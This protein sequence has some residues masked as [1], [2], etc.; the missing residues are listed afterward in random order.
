M[1]SSPERD[2]NGSCNNEIII[3]NTDYTA[4]QT[5]D[6]DKAQDLLGSAYSSNN[7]Y[8]ISFC[9]AR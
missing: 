3:D 6:A 2:E 5:L 7:T 9:C 1:C 8:I 4:S